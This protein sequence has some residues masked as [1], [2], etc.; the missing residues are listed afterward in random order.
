MP[1]L[2]RNLDWSQATPVSPTDEPPGNYSYLALRND[3]PDDLESAV[4][5]PTREKLFRLA[6]S[7]G[8]TGKHLVYLRRETLGPDGKSLASPEF[9]YNLWVPGEPSL[10]NIDGN[11]IHTSEITII[12]TKAEV[13][14]EDANAE[15]KKYGPSALELQRQRQSQTRNR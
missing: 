3:D 5:I 6:G 8:K 1:S 11:E 4:D 14:R 9:G 15:P 12:G 10:R 13:K 2:F 7:Q